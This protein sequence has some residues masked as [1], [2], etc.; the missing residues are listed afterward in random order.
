MK[1]FLFFVK[2]DP[3]QLPMQ[4]RIAI[5]VFYALSLTALLAIIF[6]VLLNIRT[7]ATLSNWIIL[8]FGLL[9]LLATVAFFITRKLKLPR[10]IVTIAVYFLLTYLIISG[11]GSRGLSFLYFVASFSLLYFVLGYVS[12]IG[13]TLYFLAGILLRLQLGD[14][15]TDSVFADPDLRQ[16][17]IAIFVVASGLG[18]I[19]VYYQHRLVSR[20]THTAYFDNLTGLSNR[21][22][23]TELLQQAVEE[24]RD[25]TV[26]ALKLHQFGKI[27]SHQGAARG[28]E[29]LREV[30]QR[31]QKELPE[32]CLASRWTGTMFL[33]YLK[34]LD[35]LHI[36]ELAQ[37][38]LQQAQIPI[39]H[40]EHK[41][42]LQAAIALT[43]FPQD[44]SNAERLAA[45]VAGMLESNNLAIGKVR[46]Y[47]RKNWKHEQRRFT[48]AAALEGAIERNE[49]NL[50]YQPKITL[51]A[52]G[53]HGVEVLL[54]WT[55]RELGSIPP[56]EFI[57]IAESGP[58]M[59]RLTSYVIDQALRDWQHIQN[60]IC[61]S[62]TLPV[63]AIN[64]SASDLENLDLPGYICSCCNTNS[65]NPEQ[66]ELEITESMMM[67]DDLH[68][69]TVINSLKK[70]GFRLAIDDFGTGYSNLSNLQK[71]RIDNLKID[72]SFVRMINSDAECCPLVDTILSMSHS[73]GLE[74][75]AEGVETETQLKYLK[76]HGCTNVQGWYYA[77]ALK[78]EELLEWL[79]TYET[80]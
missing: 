69:Q 47:D 3:N 64:L 52:G 74:T 7:Q 10:F 13:F 44:G 59:Q 36:R 9:M 46:Y 71:I 25:F 57:P 31:I 66:V 42:Q 15:P 61:P 45:N 73:L 72:Q 6:N 49:I 24:G 38:L 29:L 60:R 28:D 20:L 26:L 40:F 48:I 19:A 30:S 2:T 56:T 5:M 37:K 50:A 63:L 70:T 18:S 22:R 67:A 32:H 68:A 43:R 35:P 21:T 12:G 1:N 8:S 80:P 4:Q 14:F 16:R 54:R 34:N 75:T 11:G 58:I 76:E 65:I 23:M 33:L 78:L 39:H 77:P 27:S 17:L 62:N 79:K 51:P 41:T 55:N 53:F